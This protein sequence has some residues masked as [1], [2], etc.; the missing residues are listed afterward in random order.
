MN[1]VTIDG[2]RT[3]T[4][5][6]FYR[7]AREHLNLDEDFGDNLDALRDALTTDVP[8]PVKI[9]WRHTGRARRA[10]GKDFE[11]LLAVLEG[12]AQERGDLLLRVYP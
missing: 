6:D 7:Q 12:A 11:R 4:L 2:R 1:T 8:G 10:L 9:R 3:R 5:A